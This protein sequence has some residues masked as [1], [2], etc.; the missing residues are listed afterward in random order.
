MFLS[1]DTFL[2]YHPRQTKEIL[3][4]LYY[5]SLER[6]IGQRFLSMSPKPVGLVQPVTGISFCGYN[7]EKPDTCL[8][9]QSHLT[10][11]RFLH[12]MSSNF[13]L[14]DL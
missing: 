2:D 11:T 10:P 7:L 4:I 13:D 3:T 14:F 5:I 8:T 1:I 6:V 12:K 9:G